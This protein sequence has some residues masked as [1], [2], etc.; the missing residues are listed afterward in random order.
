MRGQQ[1]FPAR[2]LRSPA[3]TLRIG[4][5]RFFIEYSQKASDLGTAAHFGGAEDPEPKGSFPGSSTR[6]EKGHLGLEQWPI[7]PRAQGH[8]WVPK[9]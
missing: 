4:D 8:S 6:K 3:C 2:L 7:L 5:H 9:S 1:Y